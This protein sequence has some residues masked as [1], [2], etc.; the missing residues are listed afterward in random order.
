MTLEISAILSE[1]YNIAADE[2]FEE[3]SAM[4]NKPR[5]ERPPA[6]MYSWVVNCFLYWSCIE[7]SGEQVGF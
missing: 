5:I 4:K 6:K 1:N 2:I 7:A 3:M